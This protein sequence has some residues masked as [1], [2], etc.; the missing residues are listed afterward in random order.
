M[1]PKVIHYIWL[2]GKEKSKLTNI[3]IN[4]WKERLPDY[5]IIEW[6]EKNLDLNNI[7]NNNRFFAECRKRKL[8]AFMAD[9]LRLR[10]LYEQGGIYM[11]TDVQVLKNL[12]PLLENKAFLGK[13]AGN[14]IGTGLI[15]AEPK[16]KAIKSILDFYDDMIWESEL[17]TIPSIITY[18][19]NKNGSNDIK[20]Y[21]M[22]YFAPYD[23]R[24][25]YD[26][27]V[28]KDNTYAIHWFDASWSGSLSVKVFMSTKHIKNS[29]IKNIIIMKKIV[30]FYYLKLKSE[31]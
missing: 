26:Y 5:K 24:Y 9:Y 11:D 14:Y 13:E 15:A 1:I 2:G 3:C 29:F 10:I 16:N 4:S 20:V 12:S 8:W 31:N 30:G 25:P 7:S 21:P 28:I 23:Y 18:I 27:S 22:E 19:F 17:Y 6:N